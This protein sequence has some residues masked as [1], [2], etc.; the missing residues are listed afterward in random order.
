MQDTQPHAIKLSRRI[1]RLLATARKAGLNYLVKEIESLD[2]KLDNEDFYVV[3]VGQF[4]RGKS[5]LINAL[6]GVPLAPVAVTPL[7]SA[8]TI[9]AHGAR[10]YGEVTFADGSRTEVS[11]DELASYIS[12]DQNA[13]NYKQVISV[14]AYADTPILHELNLI[15]TPGLGS[16]YEHNNETTLRFVPKIDVAL[17]VLSA[18][19]PVSQADLDFLRKIKGAVQRFVFVLNKCDLL[20][21]DQLASLLNYNQQVIGTELKIPAAQIELIPVSSKSIDQAKGIDVLH[22]RLRQMALSEKSAILKAS[23]ERQFGE[24]K[25]LVTGMLKLELDALLMPVKTLGE[26]LATFRASHELLVKGKGEF[27][28]LVQYKIK[29]I[30]SMVHHAIIQESNTLKTLIAADLENKYPH[31]Q[32]SKAQKETLKQELDSLILDHYTKAK[33]TMELKIKA[34]FGN[35]L[36]DFNQRSRSFINELIK[37]LSFLMHIDLDMLTD[38]FDL[39]VYTSFY[40]T[41]N[42]EHSPVNDRGWYFF[43]LGKTAQRGRSIQTWLKHYEELLI[44]NNAAVIYDL[45]YKA[46]EALRQ[47]TY[48]L[49]GH[50]TGVVQHIEGVIGQA[51]DQ[52]KASAQEAEAYVDRLKA[53]IAEV[54]AL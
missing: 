46:Q 47:F 27:Q 41:L 45:Q 2:E 3:I 28:Q 33:K 52:K 31:E 40:L 7:T 4:K 30:D 10:S 32:A 5:S 6:L 20:D 48:D 17:L 12:E 22:E 39:N 44:I 14:T 26:Q 24:L 42:M 53:V 36:D 8:I 11:P 35:V 15:D 43:L 50:F 37:Q 34:L 25:Q 16:V 18:D 54:A 21:K 49:N 9:F 29:E 13:E 38:R 23:T 19:T 1:K 51:L